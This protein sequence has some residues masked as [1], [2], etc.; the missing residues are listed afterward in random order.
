MK[1][2]TQNTHS[3]GFEGSVSVTK[4]DGTLGGSFSLSGCTEVICTVPNAALGYDLNVNSTTVSKANFDVDVTCAENFHNR[5]LASC[6]VNGEDIV[7]T[8]CDPD[9]CVLP[10]N[11][12]A[13]N[14][15]S[16]VV[17]SLEVHDFDVQNVVCSLGHS[18]QV[19]VSPCTAHGGNALVSGCQEISCSVPTETTGYDL[20]SFDSQVDDI[21]W[22]TF[23][24]DSVECQS[25]YQG[26]VSVQR[27][28]GTSGGAFSLSGCSEIQCTVPDEAPDSIDMTNIQV[29]SLA[30]PSFD[31]SGV[32]CSN[33]GYHGSVTVTPCSVDGEDISFSGCSAMEC[34]LPQSAPLGI[35]LSDMT[36]VSLQVPTFH[37]NGGGCSSHYK[38]SFEAVACS[39]HNGEVQFTGCDPMTCTEMQSVP[40]GY[41]ISNMEV[42][43]LSA[44]SLNVQGV[45][46]VEVR[47]FISCSHRLDKFVI[48]NTFT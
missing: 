26:I 36:V 43:S 17:T 5:A 40:V 28:S 27:C 11:E 42:L 48:H 3:Y 34:R 20:S 13:Y 38:G 2:R 32:S 10:V 16:S 33:D 4:C 14:F 24:V 30:V 1:T 45:T 29:N 8:G 39:Q 22:T 47:I 9:T 21:R 31:V 23:D 18:G 19:T 7:L 46:C 37:I 35:D 41:D 44:P 12:T 25:G 15:D 6:E